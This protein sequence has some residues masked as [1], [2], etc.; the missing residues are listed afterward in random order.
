MSDDFDIEGEEGQSDVAIREIDVPAYLFLVDK[1]A[2]G[3]ARRAYALNYVVNGEGAFHPQWLSVLKTIVQY[4]ELG[5]FPEA[6]EIRAIKG[7]K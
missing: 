1:N 6:S 7:G 4:L 2:Q 5:T 3:E